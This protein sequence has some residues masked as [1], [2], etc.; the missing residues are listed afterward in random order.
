LIHPLTFGHPSSSPSNVCGLF[1]WGIVRKY[2]LRGVNLSKKTE[3]G[4]KRE[5]AT[6]K[7]MKNLKKRG[8]KKENGKC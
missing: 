6:T 1:R 7:I 5:S 3:N 8:E 4:K 2:L